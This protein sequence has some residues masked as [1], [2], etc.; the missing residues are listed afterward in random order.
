M[1]GPH[2]GPRSRSTW[3]RSPSL[4]FWTG[5]GILAGTYTI[6]ALGLQVNVGFTG[7]VNFG[8]AGF[9]AIGAYSMAILVT[10]PDCRSGSRCPS[11]C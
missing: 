9:M 3:R 2:R 10:K 4:G 1:S 5:V 6:F 8:Q 11:R 7:I